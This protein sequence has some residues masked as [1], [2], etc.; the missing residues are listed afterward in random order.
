[1]RRPK[2]S[3]PCLLTMSF[4][5]RRR[6]GTSRPRSPPGIV[7]VCSCILSSRAPRRLEI[8]SGLP[9]RSPRPPPQPENT[10]A[11]PGRIL[12][13]RGRLACASP[14][15][16]SA[17]AEPAAQIAIRSWS[18]TDQAI[19]CPCQIARGGVTRQGIT[20]LVEWIVQAGRSQPRTR[21]VPTQPWLPV[22]PP[23]LAFG[24]V[25]AAQVRQVLSGCRTGL[26]LE[27]P[28][29]LLVGQRPEPYLRADQ[30]REVL[31]FSAVHLR[32]RAGPVIEHVQERKL[33]AGLRRE[34]Q[35]VLEQLRGIEVVEQLLA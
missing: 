6:S 22:T 28:V 32:L 27:P 17:G 29:Q 31:H 33:V 12:R 23:T 2:A 24:K 11:S 13:R 14:A 5:T 26:P 1:M 19:A 18:A 10:T 20:S 4:M 30:T 16:S 8:P 35:R 25:P 9:R 3:R 7:R 34:T 15:R 21:P